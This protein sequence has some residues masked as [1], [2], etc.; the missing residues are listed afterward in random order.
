MASVCAGSLALMDAGVPI[1]EPVA[2]VAIGL[3]TKVTANNEIEDFRL[4]TDLLV[5]EENVMKPLLQGDLESFK[6]KNTSKF[7]EW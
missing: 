5:C 7:V 1:S 4:L 3:V 2:G 6:S